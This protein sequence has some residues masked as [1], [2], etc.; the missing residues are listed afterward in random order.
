MLPNTWSGSISTFVGQCLYTG[1]LQINYQNQSN[2]QN[3][4]FQVN[5]DLSNADTNCPNNVPF[6]MNNSQQEVAASINWNQG[7]CLYNGSIIVDVSNQTSNS[8]A[9]GYAYQIGIAFKNVTSNCQGT[10]NG[11]NQNGNQNGN[12]QKSAL[13]V[14]GG[15]GAGGS[16]NGSAMS[17]PSFLSG[18]SLLSLLYVVMGRY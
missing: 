8:Y 13:N 15:A 5:L 1:H 9:A 16:A 14:T 7:N 2:G 6:N 18:F 3:S 11:G 10:L 4:Q 12:F 17:V